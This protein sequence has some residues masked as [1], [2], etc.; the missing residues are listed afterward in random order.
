V[1]ILTSIKDKYLKTSIERARLVLKTHSI[2]KALLGNSKL[3]RRLGVQIIVFSTLITVVIIAV[4]LF[5]A[6]RVDVLTIDQRI[7]AIRHVNLPTLSESVWQEDENRIQNQLEGLLNLDDIE[8][9]AITADGGT[10]WLVGAQKSIRRIEKDLP[11]THYHNGQIKSIG[12]LHVVA[13]E[14]NVF[15]RLG[16]RLVII[17]ISNAIKTLL[18]TVFVLLVFQSMVGRHLEHIADYLHRFSKELS[19]DQTLVLDRSAM[20]V[21]RPDALDHVTS[22]I[23]V[24]RGDLFQ[25]GRALTAAKQQLES[26]IRNSPLAIYT[27]DLN[28]VITSWN[29]AAEKIFGWS[30]AE[31]IGQPLRT[32]PQNTQRE[33]DEI[34]ARKRRGES[35]DQIELVRLRRD[36]SNCH[37]RLSMAS[38]QGANDE[39]NGYLAIA[40]DITESKAAAR[41]LADKS[42]ALEIQTAYNEQLNAFS[43]TVSHDLKA[44]LRGI[45]GYAQELEL[46]HQ[47]ALSERARFCV[48]QIVNSGLRLDLLIDDLL[49]YARIGAE[50]PAPSDVNLLSMVQTLLNDCSP[51]IAEQQVQVTLDMPA[52][53]VRVWERGLNQVLAN[54][55]DNALKFSRNAA[56]PRLSIRGEQTPHGFLL[57]VSDNGIGFDIKYQDRVFGL[58]NR[59]PQASSFEGSGAGLA[60]VK[61]LIEKLGAKIWALS[62][63]A[64]G[65]T[66]FVEL[67]MLPEK[68]TV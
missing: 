24:M 32:L 46:R 34:T 52:A 57:S 33:Y 9:V 22:I 27:L 68:A 41:A 39:V 30:A 67:P 59:L 61:K 2:G 28:D 26:I 13:S 31:V 14:D 51:L 50:L 1:S 48:G 54:L 45:V 16:S 42:R 56:P 7:E 63:P 64:Q 55:I 29:P 43:Y 66:F 47:E 21:W 17:L 4:E 60:I 40:A 65:A 11:L 37:I 3:A 10:R 38:L 23:N 20:G 58:F 19:D 62:A 15:A 18:V 25:S 6:Y 8:Y 35:G 5:A 53:T 44:P 36:G 49:R 12:T